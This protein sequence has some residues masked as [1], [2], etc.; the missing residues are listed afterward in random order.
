MF[1][2]WEFA[3]LLPVRN[4]SMAEVRVYFPLAPFAFVERLCVSEGTWGRQL[5]SATE[6]WSYQSQSGWADATRG[7][8][9]GQNSIS[10]K[11]LP[12]LVGPALRSSTCDVRLVKLCLRC[13]RG[14]RSVPSEPAL[15]S[16]IKPVADAYWVPGVVG[17][18]DKVSAGS[19]C[20]TSSFSLFVLVFI[21]FP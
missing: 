14:L 7:G 2:L 11:P 17:G 15:V 19:S 1:P 20:C 10:N 8:S 18:L 9:S 5:C 21:R 3:E 16:H 13:G 4:L 12:P 6:T